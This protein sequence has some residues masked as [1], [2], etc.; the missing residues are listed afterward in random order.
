M[1]SSPPAVPPPFL[2]IRQ[3][4]ASTESKDTL[5]PLDGA[6]ERTLVGEESVDELVDATS[7]EGLRQ[8]TGRRRNSSMCGPGP[9]AVSAGASRDGPGLVGATGR[10]NSESASGGGLDINRSQTSL[11]QHGFSK[12][13]HSITQSEPDSGNEQRK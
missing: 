1:K 4:T 11:Y 10:R 5:T 2:N 9:G 12:R 8:R 13:Q 6:D 7:Y 3:D